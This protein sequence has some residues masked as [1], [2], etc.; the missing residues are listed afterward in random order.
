MSETTQ[1]V[2]RAEV[3]RQVE[4]AEKLLQK[5]KSAEAL[6]VYLQVLSL[7]PAND[8]VR[9]M[10]ADLCLSLQR[11][12]DASQLLGELFDH[13]IQAN[14]ATRAS[15]TYKKLARFANPTWHQKL[16]FGQLLESSNRKLAME[17]YN[18]AL[19]DLTKVG[20]KPDCLTVLKK[21]VALDPSEPH[22]VHLGGLCSELG[23]TKEAASAFFRLGQMAEASGGNAA[24]WY[25]RA[26]AE[27]SSDA[28]IALAYSRVLLTQ[29]QAGAVIFIV[30]PFISSGSFSVELRDV[31]AKALLATNQLAEAEPYIW[32]QFEENQATLPEV[33]NL[34]GAFLDA[35][36]E[37]EAVAL[38]RKLEQ[39][40]RRRGER[41]TFASMMQ[42][43]AAKHRPS[44]ELLE[45]MSEL[46]NASNRETDYCQTLLKLFDLHYGMANYAKAAECLDRAVEVDIYEPGN[47]K[48]L[49]SLRGKIDDARYQVI[50][51]RFS[52]M[53][54]NVPEP[55]RTGEPALGASTL[56][57]LM[58]QAEILVQ[59]GMRGK[60]LERLQ[61]IQ[62]L[63]PHEEERNEE[64]Q[65]LYLAAGMTPRYADAAPAP[66]TTAAPAP[67]PA[68]PATDHADVS[69]FT[70]VAE[71]TQKLN[72]QST[73]EAVLS[74]TV[75]EIGN[76]WKVARCLAAMRKPGSAPSSMKE[77]CGEGV[78]P[79]EA[80]QLARLITTLH[81]LAIKRGPLTVPDAPGAAELKAVRDLVTALGIGS[82]LALP[83]SDGSQQMGVLI[84]M[85]KSPQGWAANDVVVL[86]TISD[87][88]VIALNNAG[89]RRLV[90]NLSV[91]DE[92]SGLLKRA[93]YLDLLMGETQRALQQSLPVTVVLMQFGKAAAMVKEFGEEGVN[94]TM[95]HI[96]QLFAGNVRQ[97]DLAF[98]YETTT[99]ALV[100]GE[101]SETEAVLAMDKLR[102]L[103]VDV[104]LPGK[105]DELPFNAGIAEAVVKPPFEAV[106]IV[107]EVINR[108]EIALEAAIIQGVGKVVNQAPAIANAA[109][110]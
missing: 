70:K 106:D 36:Q 27:D 8:T 51:S 94:S 103:L 75:K 24:Q 84:L 52:G 4:K 72:R 68:A 41:K 104:H 57:D 31:Y 47:Q 90:K 95:Q 102:K 25:E 92:H 78:T 42:D 18:N 65:R 61:R 34:I 29:D 101:T 67:R 13:Q 86:K 46:F 100:L 38:A 110:A 66:V 53:S 56:Q 20:S 6:E 45:F 15:L 32:Q 83:L 98:R 1:R 58:L 14:D 16:R 80:K 10:A 33:A 93:S 2:D 54:Q 37:K 73:A 22:L 105:T 85:H 64:L 88:V 82:L 30:Q 89:L 74:T 19:E 108:A 55:A 7:D 91:T 81:D 43:I 23:E 76:H 71:I 87:Q 59:Y 60:A 109:V 79:G 107:T 49:E 28:Q 77:H 3:A 35:E 11:T 48:R 63:F 17:T 5:G 44:S 50:A 26:F 97:N 99:V 12:V 96:G 69:S 9:A 62:E 21:I 39:L 40:Q